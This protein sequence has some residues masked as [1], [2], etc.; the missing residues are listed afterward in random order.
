MSLKD[1]LIACQL[2]MDKELWRISFAGEA[3][4]IVHANTHLEA[5]QQVVQRL[6]TAE[7]AEWHYQ[8]MTIENLGRIL[9][10]AIEK[11]S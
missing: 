1:D 4:W 3:Q 10:P 9:E 7:L 8:D 6:T 5:I 2:Q 11:P